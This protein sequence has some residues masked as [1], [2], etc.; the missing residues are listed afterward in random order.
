M[1]ES[2][3][4]KQFLALT[5]TMSSMGM[6]AACGDDTTDFESTGGG[7]SGGKAGAGGSG[8]KNTGGSSAGSGGTP[9]GG[10]PNGGTP[11]GGTPNGGGAGN[12]GTAGSGGTPN[13]GTSGSGPG[14][15][16]GET[17]VGGAGGADD[18]AGAGGGG[19]DAGGA[20]AGGGGAS[21]AGGDGG[22]AGEPGGPSCAGA[23][24]AGGETNGHDH[25]PNGNDAKAVYFAQLTAHINSAQATDTFMTF[26]EGGHQHTIKLTSEQVN[27]LRSGGTVSGVA[28]TGGT[29]T[30]IY[31]LS[32]AV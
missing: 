2:I 22:T 11:N 24:L 12:A 15:E 6:A 10:T 26:S 21:G 5:L 25:V 20:G 7:G 30:H 3:N 18:M 29:H 14:G 9:N 17:M 23:A 31:T 8:G 4:R 28:T 1:A 16:G 32:C 27:T 19:A 13:G